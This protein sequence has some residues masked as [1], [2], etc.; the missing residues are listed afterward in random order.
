MEACPKVPATWACH[1]G[2]TLFRF[3]S[4]RV[5]V[6]NVKLMLRFEI[7]TSLYEYEMR[8]G[9]SNVARWQ[10]KAAGS[11]QDGQVAGGNTRALYDCVLRSF[12]GCCCPRR[13]VSASSCPESK[14]N[15]NTVL[16]RYIYLCLSEIKENKWNAR[17]IIKLIWKLTSFL[18]YVCMK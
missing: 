13:V 8:C 9:I 15:D 14:I 6:E 11:T 1:A 12:G 3:V 2:A 7:Y 4:F 18:T 16:W 17:L 5:N 10:V